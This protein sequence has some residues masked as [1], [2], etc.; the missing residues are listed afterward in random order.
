MLTALSCRHTSMDFPG[1][2]PQELPP[3]LEILRQFSQRYDHKCA[4]NEQLKGRIN[5]Q[6]L[7]LEDALDKVQELQEQINILVTQG[8]MRQEATDNQDN[9]IVP[10][11]DATR[12]PYDA[13]PGG[14]QKLVLPSIERHGIG[15]TSRG[16]S[17]A[18]I[19]HISPEDMATQQ[20]QSGGKSL[21]KRKR[22]GGLSS[23]A[24][25]LQDWAL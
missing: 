19:C 20:G 14:N 15:S 7:Q 25:V 1:H 12:R 24:E 9:V 16:A 8:D 3:Y 5:A 17:I 4:I 21:K 23:P 18:H 11:E 6:Q 2:D 10:L 22:K 13:A